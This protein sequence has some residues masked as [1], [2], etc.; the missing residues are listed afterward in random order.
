MSLDIK[1]MKEQLDR[2]LIEYLATWLELFVVRLCDSEC[3]HCNRPLP[4]PNDEDI[5]KWL[6]GEK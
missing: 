3:P 4:L 6:K 5:E 1:E 2:E